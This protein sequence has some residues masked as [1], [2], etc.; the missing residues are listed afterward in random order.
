M[1][2]VADVRENG[3]GSGVMAACVEKGVPYV[4]AGSLASIITNAQDFFVH[5]DRNL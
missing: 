4:L 5:L 2:C 3:I 1:H